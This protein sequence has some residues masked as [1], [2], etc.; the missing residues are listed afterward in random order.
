MLAMRARVRPCSALK[1]ASS[2]GRV[3]CTWPSATVT[4]M[5]AGSSRLS[6]PL[7]PL[8]FTLR[9]WSSTETP[10]GIATGILPMRLTVA[11]SPHDGEQLA[12]EVLGARLAVAHETSRRAH[13][14]HAEAVLHAR[15]LAAL[16]VAPQAGRGDAAQLADDRR[17]VVVLEVQPEHAVRAVIED[18]EIR[19][20]VVVLQQPRELALELAHRHVHAPVARRA[21]VADAGQHVRYG[22]CQAHRTLPL[23]AGLAH[24]GDHPLQ[25]EIAEADSAQAELAQHRARAAAPLAAAHHPGLELRHALRALDPT[26]LRHKTPCSGRAVALPLS[27]VTL[28]RAAVRR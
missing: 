21:G 18:L 11:S 20:V 17:L 24:A 19:D 14:G 5:P 25:R 28:P 2:L 3:T 12:A 4:P 26:R 6:S 15:H 22:I 27:S 23:P 16:H 9:S 10:L 1:R 13:D 8:T 7:G